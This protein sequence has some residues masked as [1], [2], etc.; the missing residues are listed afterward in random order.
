MVKAEL[1]ALA[2]K[3]MHLVMQMPEGMNVEPWVQSK[4]AQAKEMV[5][6]VHDYMIYGD[7]EEEQADTPITFPN[8][9][10]DTGRI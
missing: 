8:T 4:I 3:A 1:R 6:T 10:V 7:H 5:S 9:N 2:N